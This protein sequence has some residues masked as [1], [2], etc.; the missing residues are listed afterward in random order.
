MAFSQLR[1]WRFHLMWDSLLWKRSLYYV[2]YTIL[3]C[4]LQ[5]LS[6]GRRTSWATLPLFLC[7]NCCKYIKE[8]EAVMPNMFCNT[9]ILV[10][11][12]KSQS[13]KSSNVFGLGPILV[14]E[15][16][17]LCTPICLSIH[18]LIY[19]QYISSFIYLSIR[20]SIYLLYWQEQ[21]HITGSAQNVSVSA[22][23]IKDPEC[24]GMI[25]KKEKALTG[26]K[27]MYCILKVSYLTVILSIHTYIYRFNPS[28]YSSYLLFIHPSIHPSIYPFIFP[29]IHPSTHP[30]FHPLVH[31]STHLSIHSCISIHLSIHPFIYSI[32]PIIHTVNHPL[33]HS[34]IR[35]SF[36]SLFLTFIFSFPFSSLVWYL[37]SLL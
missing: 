10:M 18:S 13:R 16:D 5:A 6:L 30:S 36:L 21:V 4:M 25:F 22:L 9:W 2:T 28:I 17:Y 14:W 37:Y 31:S 3:H 8:R 11:Q 15:W 19:I 7:I 12:I 33:I 34:F 35:L 26:W 20:S 24:H 29:P 23:S 32:H 1:A 27:R